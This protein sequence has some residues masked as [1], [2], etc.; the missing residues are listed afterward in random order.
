M[1]AEYEI[2]IRGRLGPDDTDDKNIRILNRCLEWRA[3]GLAY[4]ADPRHA[5]LV[6]K[7][8]GLEN[9]KPM[10]TPG[11]KVVVSEDEDEYLAGE[12]ATAYRRLVARLNFLA[13][14]RHD[15]AYATKEL[16]RG[17]A[18]P[19]LS[20]WERLKRMG[21]YLVGRMRYVIMYH[22]QKDTYAINAFS[23]SDWAGDLASRKS[24]TGGC[25]MIGDHC[26]KA[27]SVNQSVI[28]LSS[29][30]AE[31]YALTRAA[32]MALGAQSLLADLGV[33][34]KVRVL[35]DA[36]TGKAIASRRGLGKVRH[37][38]THELWIQEKVMRGNIELIKIKNVFNTADLFTKHLDRQ[39]M[40][41]CV[42]G[43]GH[44]FEGGRN[45]EAPELN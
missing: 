31:F 45:L 24:T 21:R 41:S 30:E 29:G 27:W 37:I 1:Q 13:Q 6:V 35:T 38:A 23:D 40:D 25:L 15:I 26:I 42:T 17:M 34:L 19:K 43:M 4:E 44:R 3:D 32:A 18:N 20:D 5:E 8:L 9:S 11:I 7:D 36:T 39:T 2:K 16:A 10:V 14:D 28:A 12:E 22:F 33:N